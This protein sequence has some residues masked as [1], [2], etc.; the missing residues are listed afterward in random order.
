MA[1]A[2][3][4]CFEHKAVKRSKGYYCTHCGGIMKS[5]KKKCPNCGYNM[6]VADTRKRKMM[7]NDYYGIVT[8]CQEYQVIRIF[9]IFANISVGE[10][11]HYSAYEVIQQWIDRNGD[12][13]YMAKLRGMA[14][15]LDNWS[16]GSQLEIRNRN[17]YGAYDPN[18]TVYPYM[19]LSPEI[20]RNG[21]KGDFHGMAPKS[22]FCSILSDNKIESL[23][24]MGQI[25]LFR[26]AIKTASVLDYWQS[27]LICQRH[28]YIVDDAENW[29]DMMRLLQRLG[30]DIRSPKY[31]MP[32]DI[33]AA[34][35]HWL[36]KVQALEKKERLEREIKEAAQKEDS[37]KDMKGKFFGVVITDKE[38]TIK[39]L[40]SVK[41][42][43]IEGAELHH[44][45][46][47]GNY[48]MRRN[49]LILSA[50]VNGERTETIEIDLDTMTILQCRGLQNQPSDYHDRIV[51]LMKRNI[52]QIKKRMT[53]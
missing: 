20:R 28:G 3:R 52:H 15:Y 16:Y 18:M 45:V 13:T 10:S 17:Q 39:V 1:Y 2:K 48:A 5:E 41:E 31:I 14:Y 44:C 47:H 22:F 34:H 38:I 32:T 49:S 7:W 8:R 35:D 26:E 30:K 33:K 51:N 50:V 53:A 42:H 4:H 23:L 19:S 46:G 40:E 36:L 9:M 29:H 37:F 43:I 11:A 24:K 21:F 27:M 12:C 6:E 25:A